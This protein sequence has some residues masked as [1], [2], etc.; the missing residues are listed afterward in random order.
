MAENKTDSD[1]KG[2]GLVVTSPSPYDTGIGHSQVERSKSNEEIDDWE[3]KAE[4]VDAPETS[5]EIPV[6]YRRAEDPAAS[7]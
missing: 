1:T 3:E 7:A 5:K 2:D 6:N 4:E